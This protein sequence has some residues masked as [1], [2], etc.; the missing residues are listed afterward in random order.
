METRQ[1][2]LLFGKRK[3]GYYRTARCA[4]GRARLDVPS[5]TDAFAPVVAIRKADRHE[6]E[7]AYR[8]HDGMLW[9]PWS[10]EEAKGVRNLE[11]A[12][13]I[14]ATL[15]WNDCT[16]YDDR[17]VVDAFGTTRDAERAFLRGPDF[18]DE[19]TVKAI[20][21]KVRDL[22]YVDGMLHKR[23]YGPYF[24]ISESYQ[25]ISEDD[26]FDV[27]IRVPYAFEGARHSSA[28]MFAPHRY[29]EMTEFLGDLG[30]KARE[31]DEALS[32]RFLVMDREALD[33]I[34]RE[35]ETL[36][37]TAQIA[38][39]AL[40][41]TFLREATPAVADALADLMDATDIL[42]P[43]RSFFEYLPEDL[44]PM[45]SALAKF[46]AEYLLD[47]VPEGKRGALV[48]GM[49]LMGLDVNASLDA[50]ALMGIGSP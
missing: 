44:P 7:C 25:R 37:A 23:S 31:T 34:D 48:A 32:S 12:K 50:E 43:R 49:R 21:W 1:L 26:S 4:L 41:G 35:S 15:L 28:I 36:V 42:S 5:T 33:C 29:R 14:S 10:A 11:Q 18:S 2:E 6:N 9:T 27:D 22:L 19:P 46:D 16:S 17:L 13:R 45:R 39:H 40:S 24:S 47:A 3:A 38:R 30:L 20:A 8:Y